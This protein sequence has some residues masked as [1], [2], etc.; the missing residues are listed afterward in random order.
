MRLNCLTASA[1]SVRRYGPAAVTVGRS[2]FAQI[3]IEANRT[4]HQF[5]KGLHTGTNG[6]VLPSTA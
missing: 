5:L 4:M 2:K 1:A 3:T 6:M